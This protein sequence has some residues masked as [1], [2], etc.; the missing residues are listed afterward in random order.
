[1]TNADPRLELNT[2]EKLFNEEETVWAEIILGALEGMTM[3]A[4]QSM[5]QKCSYALR[6]TRVQFTSDQ[7]KAMF[8][9]A[10]QE[11]LGGK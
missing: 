10:W 8:S 9:G 6:Q 7:R 4:A 5:L 11:P 3:E 2:K 1:M